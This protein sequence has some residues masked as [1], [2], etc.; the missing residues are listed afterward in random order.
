MGGVIGTICLGLFG[1]VAVNSNGANGLF[2]GGAFFFLK[3]IATTAFAAV[4]T[5]GF[6]YGMLYVINLF[7]P[8]KVSKEDELLGLDE[9]L[10][11]ETARD[12]E[13]ERS[14]SLKGTLVPKYK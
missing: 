7:T 2:Y 5:Y 12:V 1:T 11:G 8:M 14:L 3:Q 6:T 13:L 10:H 4:Y 9:A